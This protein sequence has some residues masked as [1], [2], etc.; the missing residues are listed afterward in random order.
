MAAL[1]F[2]HDGLMVDTETVLAECIVEV[3]AGMGATVTFEDFGHLFGTTEADA[4]WERL[5]PLWCGR[6]ITLTEV[7]AAIT[8]LF[9]PRADTLPLLPGVADLINAGR[10]EGWKVGLATGSSRDQVEARLHRLGVLA[11]FDAVV[12]SADVARGKPAPDIYLATAERL[13][14]APPDCVVLEDSLP[15]CEAAL[16][17]GM[18]VV[19]CPSPVSAHLD[20]PTASRR[21]RSLAEV[22][23][24]DVAGLLEG[25]PSPR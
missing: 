20:F 11:S 22:T 6:P 24:A 16:A 2:D 17:A 14:V 1:I 12:T 15:G 18:P 23:F 10:A 21:V 19:L 8:P 7:E 25:R 5:L 9:R 3:L 4:E 13:D